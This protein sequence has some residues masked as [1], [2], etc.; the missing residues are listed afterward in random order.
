MALTFSTTLRNARVTAIKNTIGASAVVKIRTGAAPS[1]VASPSTGTVLATL[2][3]PSEWLGTAANGAISKV[4]DWEAQAE[5]SGT[6]GHF[7]VC[8]SDGSTVHIRGSVTG[9]SGN[10]EMK[11]DNTNFAEGQ[12]FTITSFT[13]TDG[14]AGS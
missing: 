3:L 7:E 10:G 5:T 1:N 14:N 11:V 9:T 2:S 12:N 6:A 13:I 8:A 4:G